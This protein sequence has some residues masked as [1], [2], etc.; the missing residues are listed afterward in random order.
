MY[1][2]LQKNLQTFEILGADLRFA[3]Y[4]PNKSGRAG[5]HKKIC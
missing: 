3:A 4:A 2:L 1:K 5:N